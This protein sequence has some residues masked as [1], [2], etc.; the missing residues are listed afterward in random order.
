MKQQVKRTK[1]DEIVMKMICTTHSK[2]V[3]AL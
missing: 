2:Y 3:I 1:L